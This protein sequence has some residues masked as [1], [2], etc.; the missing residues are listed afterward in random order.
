[1]LAN[2]CHTRD[3]T[4]WGACF[5]PQ[6]YMCPRGFQCP[7]GSKYPTLCIPGTLAPGIGM[8]YCEKI[9]AGHFSNATGLVE[10]GTERSYL[11]TQLMP[12][13]F[14]NLLL[15]GNETN[16]TINVSF[17]TTGDFA[18]RSVPTRSIFGLCDPGKAPFACWLTPS[19]MYACVCMFVCVCMCTR[20]IFGLCG[21]CKASVYLPLKPMR[22]VY[23][24]A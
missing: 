1:M 24:Y 5:D 3:N 13:Y 23:M 19:C 17:P 6:E 2:S 20:N 7:E 4:G 16:E 21:P 9:R 11:A 22:S 12:A 10:V 18:V 14:Q 8:P 15:L